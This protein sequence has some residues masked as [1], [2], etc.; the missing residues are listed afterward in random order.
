MKGSLSEPMGKKLEKMEKTQRM[1]GKI[2]SPSIFHFSPVMITNLPLART[3]AF[4]NEVE[5]VKKID[6]NWPFRAADVSLRPVQAC[7][8]VPCV[9]LR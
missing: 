1:P 4:R 2:C 6:T 9:L 7:K 3:A 8:P 5:F